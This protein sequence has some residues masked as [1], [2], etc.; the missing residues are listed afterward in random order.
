MGL[1]PLPLRLGVSIRL[2]QF[3]NISTCTAKRPNESPLSVPSRAHTGLGS[4]RGTSGVLNVFSQDHK[5]TTPRRPSPYK[6][7]SNS[8]HACTSFTTASFSRWKT[9]M[10]AMSMSDK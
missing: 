5:I 3:V 2:W 9:G 10:A 4:S 1:S 7:Q 8:V 6:H